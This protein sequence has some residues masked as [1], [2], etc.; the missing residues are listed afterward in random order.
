[1]YTGLPPFSR[2]DFRNDHYYE[3]IANNKA[4]LFWM[5]FEESKPK[6]FFTPDFKDLIIN[7]LQFDPK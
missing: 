5:R 3:L 4:D 6:G 1:M 2:A 7:M